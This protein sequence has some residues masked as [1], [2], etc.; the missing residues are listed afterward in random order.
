MTPDPSRPK[1]RDDLTSV[2]I[3]GET[4]LYDDASDRL[5][6]LNASATIILGLC[7]GTMS[8]DDMALAVSEAARVQASEVLPQV[9]ALVERFAE[10]GLLEAAR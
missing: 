4:V 7:D 1:H 6:H 8:I 9:S 2:E 10:A 3:D 5:H